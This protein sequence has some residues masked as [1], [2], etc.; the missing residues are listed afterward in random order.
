VTSTKPLRGRQAEAA[1]NDRAVLYAARAVFAEHG[2]DAPMTAVAE[3]AGVGIGTLYRRY[4]GKQELLQRLCVLSLEQNLDAANAAL[5]A[6]D[7]WEGLCD[8][9]RACVDFGAGAFAPAAGTIV[10]TADM[11]QHARAVRRHVG[12]LVKRAQQ[13]GAVRPDVNAIDI[14]QLVQHFSRAHPGSSRPRGSATG[15]RQLAIALSGLRAGA[16]VALPRPA[17][18]AEDYESVWR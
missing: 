10:A 15:E 8:Y 14:L 11:W 6:D 17:P 7:A 16:V 9:I 4:G 2:F 1:R 5:A 12:K 13:D 3:T 18:R